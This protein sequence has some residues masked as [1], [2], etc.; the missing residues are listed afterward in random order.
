VVRAGILGG[1]GVPPVHPDRVVPLNGVPYARAP[2]GK[3]RGGVLGASGPSPAGPGA[4]GGC[5][6]YW[7]SRDQ[8]VQDNWA[9][10]YAQQEALALGVPLGT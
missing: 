7:M 6:V 1:P 4:H 8:R 5:V 2:V 3:G 10:L 9:L